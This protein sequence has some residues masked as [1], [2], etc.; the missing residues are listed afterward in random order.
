MLEIADRL[1]AALDAGRVLAVATAV[2]IE[3]SAPRTVGTSMAFDGERVIGSIA[4]G[5]VEAA[6]VTVAEEVLADGVSQV[7]EYGV[8][9]ETAF[10][11]GLTCGG[12]LRIRVEYVAPGHPVIAQL[13]AAAAGDPAGVATVVSGQVPESLRARVEAELETRIAL[14]ESALTTIDCDG[15]LVEVFFEVTTTRPHFVIL[16]AMEFSTALAAAASVLGYRVTVCDPR[17]LFATPERFPTA[18]VVV[19]WPQRILPTLELDARSA[20][21]V[22]SHDVRFDAQAIAL[23]LASPAGY[24]GAMGSRRTHDRRVA[25]LREL[26]VDESALA[27]LRSPIGLDLGASTPEETAISIL[28][29]VIAVRTGASAEALASTAGAIHRPRLA[30]AVPAL[31]ADRLV[32]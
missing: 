2:S 23:A 19:G 27:R 7:V 1:L 21:C 29:E 14:G 11:V 8:D 30:R 31:E 6:V 4:G 10:S 25:S 28:A 3:G 22:L 16:G 15:S 13:R 17:S 5:C 26:G 12:Q 32:G 24:V 9:D 20:I 18:T